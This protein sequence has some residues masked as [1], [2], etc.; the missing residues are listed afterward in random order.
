MA[1]YPHNAPDIEGSGQGEHQ[2]G[3]QDGRRGELK[4]AMFA[5]FKIRGGYLDEEQNHQHHVND[6][7]YHIVYNGLDLSLRRGPGGLN[8]PGHVAGRG[9]RQGETAHGEYNNSQKAQHVHRYK[10]CSAGFASLPGTAF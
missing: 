8:G 5:V 10:G 6:R 4:L 1:L 7:E 9:G 3:K 2:T